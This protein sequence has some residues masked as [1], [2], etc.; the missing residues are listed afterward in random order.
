MNR[1]MLFQF[2]AGL[3]LLISTVAVASVAAHSPLTGALDLPSHIG[4]A[5]TL[6]SWNHYAV[7]VPPP[8]ALPVLGRVQLL[9]NW[10]VG[11]N[12][13]LALPNYEPGT[14]TFE[15]L[16]IGAVSGFNSPVMAPRAAAADADKP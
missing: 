4:D 1:R 16:D 5:A 15:L 12:A 3:A 6:R 2:V 10:E 9:P 11:R 7:L 8:A 13:A 14:V